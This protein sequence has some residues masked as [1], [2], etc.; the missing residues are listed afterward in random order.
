[1]AKSG[2]LREIERYG[3]RLALLPPILRRA[4]GLD[5]LGVAEASAA[6]LL[7][8]A[9]KVVKTAPTALSV[10][11]KMLLL[12]A[13]VPVGVAVSSV[14]LSVVLVDAIPDTTFQQI[15][16]QTTILG[17]FGVVIPILCSV[18]VALKLA[19]KDR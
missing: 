5:V 6:G 4:D 3:G 2:V 14:V 19:S 11:S 10:M 8:V 7:P 16:L 1:M 12:S 15:A 17:L 18:P 13:T 9:E